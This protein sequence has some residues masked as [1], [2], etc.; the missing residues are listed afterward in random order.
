MYIH[1]GFSL[2]LV[3]VQVEEVL[4]EVLVLISVQRKVFQEEEEEKVAA[5]VV[6]VEW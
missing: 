3:E 6:L 5:L 4:E 1:F 2:Q